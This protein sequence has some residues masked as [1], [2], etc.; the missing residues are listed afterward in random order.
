MKST[1]HIIIFLTIL[2]ALSSCTPPAIKSTATPSQA[3]T[4]T[5]SKTATNKPS[6]TP[7][8]TETPTPTLEPSPTPKPIPSLKIPAATICRKMPSE[9]GLFAHGISKDAQLD[10]LGKDATENWFLV[11]NPG[12]SGGITC[13]IASRNVEL[14]GDLADIPYTSAVQ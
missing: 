8:P 14:I 5:I 6:A 9:Y 3:P 1:I 10:L 2:I 13:W 12:S 4:E 11:V 7:I